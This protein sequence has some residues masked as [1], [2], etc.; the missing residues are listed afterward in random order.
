MDSEQLINNGKKILRELSLHEKISH[1]EYKQ[2]I[3]LMYEIRLISASEW[4][5][6]DLVYQANI[7]TKKLPG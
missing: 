1:R 3:D 4:I 2:L 6:N 7:L 5:Q